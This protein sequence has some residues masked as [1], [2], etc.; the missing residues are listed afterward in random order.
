MRRLTSLLAIALFAINAFA[1]DSKDTPVSSDG[2]RAVGDL[3]VARHVR[4]IGGSDGAGLCVYTSVQMASDWHNVPQFYG[5][6]KFASK[7]PGGSYPEKL[8]KDITT[9]CAEQ[10]LPVPA[11][12]QHVGGDESF[13]DLALKTGR[14]LGVTYAGADGFY[15]GPVAH[16]VNLVHLDKELACIVDNNRPGKFVWMTRKQFINRWRG[17][18]DN[19]SLMTIREGRNTYQIGGGWAFCLLASPPPP[20]AKA[21]AK[22][23]KTNL[24]DLPEAKNFGIQLDKMQPVAVEKAPEGDNFGVNFEKL[25][26]ERKFTLNGTEVTQKVAEAAVLADDSTRYHLTFVGLPAVT[27]PET[28]RSVCHVQQYAADEWEVSQFGL[29]P[30]VT[31][32]KP[33]T[34]RVGAEVYQSPKYDA[35]EIL[36]AISGSAPTPKPNPDKP[37]WGTITISFDELPAT[38]QAELRMVGIDVFKLT[39]G[40]NMA[41]KL[42]TGSIKE[43]SEPT[44]P[45]WLESTRPG[46]NFR[47]HLHGDRWGWIQVGSEPVSPLAP[48]PQ[49]MPA[50]CPPGGCRQPA[51]A[52]RWSWSPFVRR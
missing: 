46:Q 14:I 52:Q 15:S 10:K 34:A 36:A 13:L 6:Q 25:K 48:V 12:I 30:G 19:G 50:T 40:Q 47:P 45:D 24:L 11:Y 33:Q 21:P 32:R 49:Q 9:Y 44:P 3:P 28:I 39:L 35:A 23:E 27:L 26:A 29:K 38:K 17:V 22:T 41:P 8:D 2:T 20:Y 16:M 1:F 4:N 37:Q 5:F 7:R 51:P 42:K 18:Y 43:E 31:L